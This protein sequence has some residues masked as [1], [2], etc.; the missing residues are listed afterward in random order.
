MRAGDYSFRKKVEEAILQKSTYIGTTADAFLPILKQTNPNAK[1]LPICLALTEPTSRRSHETKYDFVYFA[2]SINKAAD[3]AVEA[4]AIAHIAHPEITL[5]IVGGGT[6]EFIN[7]LNGR[8]E[9]LGLSDAI[10]IE[11]RLST[12]DDVIN[13]IRKSKFALLPLKVD[14]ISGTIREAMANGLPVVTTITSATPE[15]NEK[16]EC[17]LLSVTGDHHAMAHNMC[18]L[19]ENKEFA[20]CLSVNCL[21]TS[22][23]KKTNFDYMKEWLRTYEEIIKQCI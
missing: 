11:G 16:R 13:Q 7:E 6:S 12:H 5:D 1:V 15:L 3:L 2:S 19:I 4:F 22:S 8:I 17:A 14:L 10:T 18:V 20:E 23:E 9:A 21:V